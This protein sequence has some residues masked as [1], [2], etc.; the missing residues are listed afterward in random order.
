[1]RILVALAIESEFAPWRRLDG[2]DLERV[3]RANTASRAG[4]VATASI[5]NTQVD[6]LLTGM[7]APNARRAIREALASG[8][9]QMCI[10]AGLSGGLVPTIASEEIIA[11]E[12]I[13]NGSEEKAV[14]SDANLLLLAETSGARRVKTLLTADHIVYSA[15][16]KSAL[17][18][19]ADIVDMESFEFTAAA[20][21]AQVPFVAI[22]AISDDAAAELP[23]GLETLV[24]EFGHAKAGAALRMVATRP[25]TVRSL[26]RLGRTSKDASQK[27]AY[28]VRNYIEQ[29]SLQEQAFTTQ[30]QQDLQRSGAR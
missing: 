21:E 4:I 12:S 19:R 23:S 14:R 13:R 9:Y 29:I 20:A 22:R 30:D 26:M 3:K 1:M 8:T 10:A 24:D 15:A 7:G 17:A 28:F 2:I 6:F 25:W 5:R 11:P 27:L 18:Q 16:E